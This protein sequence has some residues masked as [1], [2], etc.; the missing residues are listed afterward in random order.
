MQAISAAAAL[1]IWDAGAERN[2]YER[3]VV[4]LSHACPEETSA[5]LNELPLGRAQAR[6]LQSC[7]RSYGPH[8]PAVTG[9]PVCDERLEFELP[10][11]VVLQTAS[12]ETG[13]IRV[14]HEGVTYGFRLS[15]CG[16]LV[17]VL[18]AAGRAEALLRRCEVTGTGAPMPPEVAREAE[19]RM[20]AADP[21]AL[22]VTEITCPD[23]SHVW[24]EP[25]DVA[26]FF[27]REI[28]ERAAATL[29]E[30]HQ[31]ARA[32]GWSEAAIL[33]LSAARRRHYL[34]LLDR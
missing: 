29:T 34:S 17:A 15:G 30:V 23:C 13:I 10:L 9:F 16:D 20:A 3:A 2:S 28:A 25:L 8:R 11:A 12:S 14:L 7:A 1:Q 24:Q 27:F 18:D 22:V 6:L 33:A 19:R 26:D 31:L 32:Y 4:M 5:A 21:L